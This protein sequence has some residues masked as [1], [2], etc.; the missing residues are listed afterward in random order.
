MPPLLLPLFC[1]P[2]E[3]AMATCPYVF[4]QVRFVVTNLL[5]DS[6]FIISWKISQHVLQEAKLV[7][8][9]AFVSD[10]H[11]FQY[12]NISS[13]FFAIEL[14]SVNNSTYV[15]IESLQMHLFF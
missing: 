6:L 15:C 11:V 14:L 12:L 3:L 4:S 10:L 8:V 7:S 2:V 13:F 5:S 9:S 1:I